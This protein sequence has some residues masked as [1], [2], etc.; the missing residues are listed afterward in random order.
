MT[1]GAGENQTFEERRLLRTI[2]RLAYGW[3]SRPRLLLQ[4]GSAPFFSPMQALI[5]RRP[6]FL[7]NEALEL[8]VVSIVGYMI[9]YR[10][11]FFRRR[12]LLSMHVS[13]SCARHRP[14]HPLRKP[15][16]SQDLADLAIQMLDI[17]YARMSRAPGMLDEMPNK[18][19]HGPCTFVC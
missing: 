19:G 17:N 13:S 16:S 5:H 4:V 1:R 8:S 2:S 3:L 18:E 9:R 14:H 12:V 15:R 7:V 11:R 6:H 10:S